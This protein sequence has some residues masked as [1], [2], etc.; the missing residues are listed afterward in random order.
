LP[1]GAGWSFM[2]FARRH[3]DY[4]LMGVA[5]WIALDDHGTCREAHLVYLNAGNGPIEARSAAQLLQGQE[6][7]DKAI[8]AAAVAADREI[9]PTG[10][11]HCTPAYQR[12]LAHVLTRRAL[13]QAG[14][15]A[16]AN[17]Q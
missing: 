2:E 11:V 12:H 9:D 5:A 3:G 13:L 10:N 1:T 15:R 16:R 4:A 14:A 17:L 8:E 7:S 6:I